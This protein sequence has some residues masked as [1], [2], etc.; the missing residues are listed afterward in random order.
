MVKIIRRVIRITAFLIL[1]AIIGFAAALFVITDPNVRIKQFGEFDMA[2]LSR[3]TEKYDLYDADGNFLSSVTKNGNL[4]IDFD[5]IGEDTKNAF[6][7][8]EDARFYEHGAIDIRRIGAAL[9]K[10]I[11]TGSAKEG[12]STITQQLVKNTYLTPEKTFSRKVREIRIARAIEQ[13]LSKDEILGL[14]LNSLYFGNNIYG[15]E[16]ASRRFFG[17][18]AAE[19]ELDES[20]ALAAIINNPAKFDPIKHRENTESRKK[21]VLERML[22]LGHI[23]KEEY[24]DACNETE[25]VTT[26]ANENIFYDHA[27]SAAAQ[28]SVRTAYEGA[29]QAH[30]LGA[31]SLASRADLTAAALVF[32]VK[33]EEIVA[34]ASNTYKNLVGMKR[35]PGSTIKP[36]LCYA[37]ALDSGVLTPVTPLLDEPTDF[38]SYKPTNYLGKY[39]GWVSATES[40]SQ[41][42]NVPAVKVL[43]INGIEKSKDVARK[44]GITFSDNDNGLALALGG[45]EYGVDLRSL[46]RAYCRIAGGG[47][48]AI[49][50]ESAYLLNKMLT[51]CA[52]SGTAKKLSRIPN[53]AAKTGTVGTETGNTDAWC[54]GYNKKYVTLVWVGAP[55]GYLPEDVTGGSLPT[56]ICAEIMKRPELRSGAFDRPETV[57]SVDIDA[58]ELYKNHRVA[59][60]KSATLPKDRVRAEFSIYNMPDRKADEDLFFGDYENFRVV[61][62]FDD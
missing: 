44:L 41:S 43:N 39:Y 56:E 30:V 42:L 6:I 22:D 49:K 11:A 19:I 5:K 57:I 54:I 10:D 17:K 9:I 50:E 55:E 16:T 27:V 35:R 25:F 36:I 28:T 13:R 21:L 40:L 32:D 7:S 45:M 24:L 29:I 60:A 62:G 3:L 26:Y 51:E 37:P 34:A 4:K 23:T 53:I 38:G 31:M 47:K 2:P 58:T 46:G 20:A 12:A 61:S 33:T 52:K 48:N 8:I 15:I 59:A 1:V 18:S 14:Y